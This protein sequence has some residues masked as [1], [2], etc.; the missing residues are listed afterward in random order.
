M[1]VLRVAV[2]AALPAH[3]ATLI[4]VVAGQTAMLRIDQAFFVYRDND[5]YHL[6]LNLLMASSIGLE[7]DYSFNGPAW[8][9]SVEVVMYAAFFALCRFAR[10]H[11]LVLAGLSLLGFFT[12]T[13]ITTRSAAE[14]VHS[15]RAGASS[16]STRR[17]WLVV[18]SGPLR[19]SRE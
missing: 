13:E 2:L 4:V 3:L 19:K 18:R 9:I 1:A 12:L 7:R 14:W 15:L 5:A 10:P 17:S 6:L 8:S 16:G 11:T